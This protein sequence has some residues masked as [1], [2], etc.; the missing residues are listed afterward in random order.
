MNACG[1]WV[2]GW[3]SVRGVTARGAPGVVGFAA[4]CPGFVFLAFCWAQVVIFV[5]NYEAVSAVSCAAVFVVELVVF[6]VELVI[7]VAELVIF[8]VSFVACFDFEL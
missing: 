6:V 1:K 2:G 5:V 4:N 7:F 8:V 3:G